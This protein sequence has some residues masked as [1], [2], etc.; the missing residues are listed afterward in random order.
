MKLPDA[1]LQHLSI[2]ADR[3]ILLDPEEAVK[4]ELFKQGILFILA[5]WAGASLL[6][7][8]ALNRALASLPKL[9]GLFLY[10][11]DTDSDSTQEFFSARKET[12]TG[13][14]E[15]YWILNGQVQ[16]KLLRY[17]DQSISTLQEYT[18]SIMP[19]AVR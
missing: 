3:L 18:M 5:K 14:G 10:V 2:G 9:D 1:Y 6:S 13:N 15:T 8:R 4:T 19:S 16:H 12:P 17:D 7:F 11:A